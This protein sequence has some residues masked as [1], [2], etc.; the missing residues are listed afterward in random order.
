MPTNPKVPPMNIP[1]QSNNHPVP[2]F[3]E[4]YQA[5][6]QAKS[7]KSPNARNE[8]NCGHSHHFLIFWNRKVIFKFR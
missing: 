5:K 3:K 1:C 6:A 2:K 8:V 7:K 4:R